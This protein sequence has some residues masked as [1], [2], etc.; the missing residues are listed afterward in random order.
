M[1]PGID[2][3]AGDVP[4]EPPSRVFDMVLRGYDRHQVDE[5]IERLE[6]RVRQHRDQA[7]ALRRELSVAQRQ[8]REGERPAQ[9]GLGLRIEQLLRL[10]EEL[11]AEIR[12]E[13]RTAVEE[14][15]AAAKADAAEL[16]AAAENEAAELRASAERET[17]DLRASAER[18]ADAV[19]SYR[20]AGG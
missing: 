1:D 9:A 8:L 18:E 16:R 10:A 20:T 17:G 13:A 3:Q 4:W 11:A 2:A 19:R 6:N 12:G 5:Q 14:L 7:Q 15:Q